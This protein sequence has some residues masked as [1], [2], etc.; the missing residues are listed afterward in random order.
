MLEL[1]QPS[2]GNLYATSH[3]F[4]K[5]MEV[6]GVKVDSDTKQRMR[7]LSRVN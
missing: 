5:V 3:V 2:V 6:V 1:A 4:P 7:R